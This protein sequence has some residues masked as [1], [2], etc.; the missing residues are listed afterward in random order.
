MEQTDLTLEDNTG[1]VSW[2][3]Q[4]DTSGSPIVDVN[5]EKLLVID[6]TPVVKQRQ[7]MAV[8]NCEIWAKDEDGIDGDHFIGGYQETRTLTKEEADKV[9]KSVDSN[10]LSIKDI[11]AMMK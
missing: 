4:T 8:R 7:L 10:H 5:G 1:D 6:T 11:T 9:Y 3:L 2:K